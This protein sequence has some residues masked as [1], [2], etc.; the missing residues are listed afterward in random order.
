MLWLLSKYKWKKKS[1]PLGALLLYFSIY[2]SFH[3]YEEVAVQNLHNVSQNCPSLYTIHSILPIHNFFCCLYIIMILYKTNCFGMTRMYSLFNQTAG[4]TRPENG[5]EQAR[6]NEV[7]KALRMAENEI[8][9][10][11]YP[12]RFPEGFE[13]LAELSWAKERWRN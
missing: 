6:R 1:K 10:R 5:R 12:K 3:W 13:G 9:P 2:S 11:K 8:S 7:W 4:I